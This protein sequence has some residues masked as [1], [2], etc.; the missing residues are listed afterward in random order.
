MA[1]ELNDATTYL[2][3]LGST[4]PCYAL[5]LAVFVAAVTRG[6]PPLLCRAGALVA[7]CGWSRAIHTCLALAVGGARLASRGGAKTAAPPQTGITLSG[8]F[9]LLKPKKGQ[10]PRSIMSV[11]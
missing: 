3:L 11:P 5:A 6:L 9:D 4:R 1:R 8:H 2:G 7:S 10:D